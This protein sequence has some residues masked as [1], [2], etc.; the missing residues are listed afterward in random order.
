MANGDI[1]I[2]GSAPGGSGG[3]AQFTINCAGGSSDD[4]DHL[5]VRT[6]GKKLH[7][8]VDNGAGKIFDEDL[9]A[10][11]WKLEIMPRKPA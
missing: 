10:P 7:I 9:E 2:T 6:Q 11:G 3:Q 4:L 5:V 1:P 8:R